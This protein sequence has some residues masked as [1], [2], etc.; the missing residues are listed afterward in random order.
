MSRILRLQTLIDKGACAEQVELFR[1]LYGDK[2]RVTQKLCVAVADKFS[3]DWAATKLLSASAG[4][5]YER[6]MAQVW[7]EYQR[8]MASAGAEYERV[9][10]SAWAEYQRVKARAFAKCYNEDKP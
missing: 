8:V 5:E 1:K 6:D 3:F 7:A 10:A 4:A 9:M 2:V